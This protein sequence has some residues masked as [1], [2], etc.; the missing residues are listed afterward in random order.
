M[1]IFDADPSKDQ[2][3]GD[4]N[5]ENKQASFLATLVKEKGDQWNDPEVI[6]KGKIEADNHIKTLTEQIEEMRKAMAEQDYSKKLLET[7]QKENKV[8]G[9]NGAGGQEGN[10]NQDPHA[11]K[12][13]DTTGLGE[14]AIKTL[15]GQALT[16]QQQQAVKAANVKSVDEVM[17]SKFGKDAAKTVAAKAQELGIDVLKLQ[18]IAEGSPQAF[19][20]LVGVDGEDQQ[21]KQAAF[22]QSSF[23]SGGN[24]PGGGTG[25]RDWSWYQAQRR[26]KGTAWLY[27]PKTQREML[28]DKNRLGDRFGM[29]SN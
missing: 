1:T 21:V 13:Q 12:A 17:T 24:N 2:T 6:A 19:F 11:A 9:E 22:N 23:T 4:E 3:K 15:V 18:E 10:Q 27:S 29:P 5:D 20:R 14:D 8:P 25:D 16:E 7:L 28:S 26:E